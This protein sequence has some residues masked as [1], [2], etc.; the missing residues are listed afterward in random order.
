LESP[1]VW[2][3]DFS[4]DIDAIDKA[5]LEVTTGESNIIETDQ[6]ELLVF[7]K[8]KDT[9]KIRFESKTLEQ[10]DKNNHFWGSV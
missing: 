3:F 10:F 8:R 2:F 1:E 6:G 7:R 4:S 5:F 9:E